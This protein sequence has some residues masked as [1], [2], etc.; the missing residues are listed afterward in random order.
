MPD[1]DKKRRM[2]RGVPLALGGVALAVGL[3]LGLWP[4]GDSAP[5]TDAGVMG[6]GSPQGGAAGYVP[7]LRGPDV[8]KVLVPKVELSS[9]IGVSGGR[10]VWLATERAALFS[11]A[12]DK[13]TPV[14][15]Y[16]GDPK[17]FGGTLAASYKRVC[18]AVLGIEPP[19]VLCLAG[20]R[21]T[22]REAPELVAEGGSPDSLSLDGE[23][24][25]WADRGRLFGW[26]PG[27]EEAAALAS[28][29]QR[30]A[31]LTALK[32]RVLWLD[33][34]YAAG[35]RGRHRVAAWKDGSTKTLATLS[36]VRDRRHLW[37]DG[38]HIGWA[39]GGDGWEIKTLDGKTVAQT[40][41]V[42]GIV[43]ADGRLYWAEAHDVD[44][45]VVTLLRRGSIGGGPAE[46][47]GRVSGPVGAMTLYQG[48][49]YWSE[50]RGIVAHR[51][52]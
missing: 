31:S 10:L 48:T 9:G 40:G 14:L 3:V 6:G 4:R 41:E 15:R 25:Y 49:L 18:W 46:R 43:A 50:T 22:D 45:G 33:I 30:F 20:A 35:A 52:K 21:L 42:T 17:A 19:Q 5:A 11:A 29:G 1:A 26:S 7:D 36:E 47:L 12:F 27:D 13:P 16:E 38:E 37:T 51:V 2:L 24:L 32:G 8:G 23:H 39:E 28:P 44:G 34:P